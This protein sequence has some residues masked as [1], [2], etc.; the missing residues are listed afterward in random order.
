MRLYQTEYFN[1][2]PNMFL[3]FLVKYKQNMN[4]WCLW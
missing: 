3:L 2:Q 1:V 4:N